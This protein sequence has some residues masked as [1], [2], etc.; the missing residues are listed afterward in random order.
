MITSR[1]CHNISN[2]QI[3]ALGVSDNRYTSFNFIISRKHVE[4][5]FYTEFIIKNVILFISKN[6]FVEQRFKKKIISVHIIFTHWL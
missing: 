1:L 3:S 5:A 2:I 4:L 6:S